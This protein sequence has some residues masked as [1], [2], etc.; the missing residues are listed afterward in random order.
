MKILWHK[1]AWYKILIKSMAQLCGVQKNDQIYGT[2]MWGAEVR[3]IT[4]VRMV[5]PVRP[6]RQNLEMDT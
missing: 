3:R 5:Y 2:T 4:V 1:Y 6:I